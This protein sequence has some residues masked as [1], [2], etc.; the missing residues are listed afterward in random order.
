MITT[1]NKDG[2][3]NAASFA[4]CV[5]QN[6]EPTCIS[7]TVEKDKDTYHNVLATGEFVVNVPSFDRE[8]LEKVRVVG[9]PF[10]PGVNELE[11]AGL[12]ALPAKVVKPPRIAECKSH[13]ECKVEWTKEWL[14]RLTVMGRVVAASVDEDCIDK[15]GYAILEKLKPAHYCGRAFDNKFVASYEVMEVAMVYQG[16]EAKHKPK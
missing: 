6:H 1:L 9:L 3:V 7:F 16:P 13:W 10:A 5:R 8:I 2:S 12:T 14:H 15:D 4:T 11:K